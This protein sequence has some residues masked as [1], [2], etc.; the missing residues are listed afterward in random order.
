MSEQKTVNRPDWF[1]RLEDLASSPHLG[2][3]IKCA[4]NHIAAIEEA[5]KK[6][7]DCN[8]EYHTHLTFARSE[9]QDQHNLI[10][11]LREGLQTIY[12]ERGEDQLIAD[13]CDPLIESS[14]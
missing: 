2:A 13:I 8:L 7:A 12:A 14:R 3:D 6:L 1:R 10:S 4:L 5:G 11:D 9:I